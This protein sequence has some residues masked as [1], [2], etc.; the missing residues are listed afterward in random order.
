MDG[1]QHTG[2]DG[3]ESALG[4]HS[5]GTVRV[6]THTWLLVVLTLSVLVPGL[7]VVAALRRIRDATGKM[8]SILE[9]RVAVG[10][11]GNSSSPFLRGAIR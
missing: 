9:A 11:E 1:S 10:Y 3:E 2:C 4:P 8:V 5:S 7:S 6:W